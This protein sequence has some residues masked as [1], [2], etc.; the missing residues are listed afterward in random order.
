M[1]LSVAIVLATISAALASQ[2]TDT[3][4]SCSPATNICHC[5]VCSPSSCGLR[6]VPSLQC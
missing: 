5:S 1:K 6:A 3:G 4:C 2:C